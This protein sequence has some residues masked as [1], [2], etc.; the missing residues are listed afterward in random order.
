MIWKTVIFTFC[1]LQPWTR[2]S[3]ESANVSHC[4]F[5]FL[6]ARNFR[7]KREFYIYIVIYKPFKDFTRISI[8]STV[9][10]NPTLTKIL[11]WERWGNE[12][13]LASRKLVIKRKERISFSLHLFYLFWHRFEEQMKETPECFVQ[14]LSNRR[15]A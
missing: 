12:D 1:L 6:A 5:Q 15:L 14:F 11:T 2:D 3:S 4:K 9:N 8:V 10:Y 13:F 7:L